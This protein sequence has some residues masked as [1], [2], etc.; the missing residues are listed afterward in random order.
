MADL[1]HVTRHI[2][3]TVQEVLP[4]TGLA[5]VVDDERRTWGITGNAKGAGVASLYPGQRIALTVT[6]HTQF[7]LVSGYAPLN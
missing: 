4:A 1:Q 3:A 5:Y 6:D 2:Q 7:D